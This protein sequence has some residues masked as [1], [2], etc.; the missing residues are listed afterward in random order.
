[1]FIMIYHTNAFSENAFSYDLNLTSRVSSG[2]TTLAEK[3][4]AVSPYA[5]CIGNPISLFDPNGTDV[6]TVDAFGNVVWK[7]QSDTHCLYYVDNDGNLS[8]DY[9]TVSDRS[10]LDDLT[11]TEVMAPEDSSYIKEYANRNLKVCDYS[12]LIPEN[13]KYA[14][15]ILNNNEL[16]KL[17]LEPDE[18]MLRELRDIIPRQLHVD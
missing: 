4:Y 17:I 5:Y 14:M 18:R 3:Y 8:E 6:W 7:E 1:M 2:D 16:I 12:S 11:K 9:V 10:I 15:V 13:K